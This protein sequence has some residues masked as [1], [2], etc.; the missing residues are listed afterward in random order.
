MQNLVQC[1]ALLVA[2]VLAVPH[3]WAAKFRF[4]VRP[5]LLTRV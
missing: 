3:A 2:V 1:M 4:L 5:Q